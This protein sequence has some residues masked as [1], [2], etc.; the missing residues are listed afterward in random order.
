MIFETIKKTLI[1]LENNNISY[2]VLRNYDFLIENREPKKHSEKSID[3]VIS[4]KDWSKFVKVMNNLGFIKRTKSY[5]LKHAPYYK[6]LGLDRVSFDI[7]IGAVH[8]NDMSYLDVLKNR[9]KK[10][11]FY[12]PSNDDTFVMLLVHSILGKRRFKPE[13]QSILTKAQPNKGYVIEKLSSIFNKK[14]AEKLYNL[15]SNEK[16]NEILKKKYLIAYFISKHPITFI[17]LFFRWI[18]WKKFLK[19][20]PLISFIGPDGAGKSSTSA[21]VLKYLNKIGYKA[22]VF[23]TGRGRNQILP[24]R[25][26]GNA[27]KSRERKKPKMHKGLKKSI[28][29]LFAPVFALDLLLRYIFII[30]P[31]RLRKNI[32]ITDRYSSDIMVMNNVPLFFKKFLLRLFPKPTITFYL[33]NTAEVLHARRPEEPINGLNK[34]MYFFNKLK[35]ILNPIE[36]I[37]RDKIKDREKVILEIMT[38]L[39]NNW[40]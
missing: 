29:T 20:W 19:P 17:K 3:M 4:K 16:F 22:Q 25:K 36:I 40:Y 30:L 33:Y 38:F 32:I 12:V 2:C 39:L 11:F 24:I 8:W 34:Q 10:S 31:N 21:E 7:Q 1:E 18:K 23:Y 13:Y 5:S 37:S 27:Y 26:L 35:P 28:Y 6:F 14:I 9:V 15:V